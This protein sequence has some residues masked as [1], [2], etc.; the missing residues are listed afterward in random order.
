MTAAVDAPSPAA[1]ATGSATQP[2]GRRTDTSI[3]EKL[4][5]PVLVPVVP[6]LGTPH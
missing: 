6:T 1:P 5:V 2:A 3:L 4:P